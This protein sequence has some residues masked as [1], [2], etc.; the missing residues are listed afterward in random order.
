MKWLYLSLESFIGGSNCAY[1]Q[2]E[3]IPTH[4]LD[5]SDGENTSHYLL[6]RPPIFPLCKK[7]SLRTVLSSH[8]W[9]TLKIEG[10]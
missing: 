3:P 2:V 1:T 4:L 7:Q 9:S 5:S 8:L 10:R 6:L